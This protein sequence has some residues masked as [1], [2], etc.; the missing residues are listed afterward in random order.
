MILIVSTVPGLAAS[1]KVLSPGAYKAAIEDIVPL[2][3][4]VT[5]HKIV[6]Q[7]DPSA[8]IAQKVEAGEEFDVTITSPAALEGFAKRGVILA[9]PIAVVG[10]N[11]VLLAYKPGRQKPDISTPDALKAVLLKANAISYSDPAAG[12]GSSNYFMSVIQQLGIVEEIEKKAIITKPAEGTF[13]VGDGRADLG[14]SQTSEVAM[15]S[16]V[17]AVP[18][19]PT[20][21]KSSSS[22]AAG[23]SSKSREVDASRAFID[24]I[25]SP[26]GLTI[27][28][29]KGL[30]PK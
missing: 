29:A 28:H 24:F 30:A 17:E 14:V 15:V 4:K 8:V 6:L 7:Y 10:V 19:N 12:G 1:L 26:E 2:F 27:R 21:P 20:D 3:E 13:P 11:S 23:I 16:G 22:Y 9:S 18:L 25:L 5:G